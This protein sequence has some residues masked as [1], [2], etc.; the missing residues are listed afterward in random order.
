MEAAGAALVLLSLFLA[1]TQ[2]D[3]PVEGLE[4]DAARKAA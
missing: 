4:D 2:Y 1:T 3:A